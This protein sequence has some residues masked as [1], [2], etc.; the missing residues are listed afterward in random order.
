VA[1]E[2]LERELHG[3][4]RDEVLDKLQHELHKRSSEET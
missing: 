3:P 1:L 4:R 2:E